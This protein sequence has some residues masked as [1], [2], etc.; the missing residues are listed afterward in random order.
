M[1]K[2][3]FVGIMVLL[4]TGCGVSGE[5]VTC[6]IGGKDAVFT[7]KNGIVVSYTFN[8]SKMNQSVID[9]INGEYLTSATNNDEGKELLKA[10]VESVNGSCE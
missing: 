5:E 2:I 7:L 8:D 1:K 3:L 10:Y 4:F 9:E 6:Q